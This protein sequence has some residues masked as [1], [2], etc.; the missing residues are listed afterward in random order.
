MPTE[1]KGSTTQAGVRRNNDG[2]RQQVQ[3]AKQSGDA[4]VQKARKT[5]PHGKVIQGDGTTQATPHSH[6]NY[7]GGIKPFKD[8]NNE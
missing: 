5:G 6:I 1:K 4:R 2:D 7:G 8:L 3:D